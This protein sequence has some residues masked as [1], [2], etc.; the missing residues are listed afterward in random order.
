MNV[1]AEQCGDGFRKVFGYVFKN[2][3]FHVF[4]VINCLQEKKARMPI[5]KYTTHTFR[6]T[7][8]SRWVFPCRA[9]LTEGLFISHSFKNLQHVTK[10]RRRANLKLAEFMKDAKF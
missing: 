10:L 6:R 2:V 8:K 9:Q 4:Q 1:F 5:E 7:W 3:K